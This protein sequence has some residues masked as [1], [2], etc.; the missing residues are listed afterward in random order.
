M[1]KPWI[2]VVV[3]VAVYL[4]AIIAFNIISKNA[5]K[6]LTTAMPEAELPVVEFCYN[7]QV[8][9]E[10]HGYV[11]KMDITGIRDTVTNIDESRQLQLHISTYGQKVDKISYEIRGLDNERFLADGE[12]TDFKIEGRNIDTVLT[13]QNLLEENEE[14]SL[15][16]I[17]SMGEK[18]VYYYTRIIQEKDCHVKECLDFA[19]TFHDYTFSDEAANFIPTYMD[20]ASGDATTLN[21]VDL[22]CTLRQITWNKF[23]GKKMGKPTISFL[24]INNNYVAIMLRYTMVNVNGENETEYYLVEEYYRLRYTKTRMYVMNF[25][26]TMNQLFN[27]ENNFITNG[28]D[29]QLGIRDK[30]VEYSSTEGGSVVAFVQQG[31]LWVYNS[32]AKEI[33]KVFS[34]R[35]VEGKDKRNN[36]NQYDINIARVDEAGSVDFIVYGYMNRGAHEGE[37]GISICHYDG[38]AHTVEEEAFIPYSKSFAILKAEMGRLMYQS[39]MGI[40]YFMMEGDVYNFNIGTLTLEKL[41]SNLKEGT[42]SASPAN[43]Y[44]AWIESH[45]EYS[46]EVIKLLDLGTG[47]EFTLKAGE[48]E[49]LRPLGFIGEDFIYGIANGSDITVNQSGKTIFPMKAIQIIDTSE[50]KMDVLK[51]YS[52]DG[53]YISGIE[54]DGYTIEVTLNTVDEKGNITQSTDLIRNKNAG[55]DETTAITTTRTDV[56]ETEVQISLKNSK[57]VNKTRMITSKIVILEEEKNIVL[58]EK[59][60]LN[61]YYVYEKGLVVLATDSLTEAI[62]A[63]NADSAVVVN[64]NQDYIWTKAK[65]TSV[66]AFRNVKV[67]S[68]DLGANSVVQSISALLEYKGIGMN[69]EALVNAG[70]TPQQI[71]ATTLQ[72]SLILDLT[73]CSVK[74]VLYYISNGYPVFASTGGNTAVL[75]IGYT[76]STVTYFNPLSQNQETVSMTEANTRFQ[77]VGN[78]F[79]TY[80]DK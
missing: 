23:E 7:E 3:L 61:R 10:L 29:I 38:I 67:N 35:E 16:L 70:S 48:G 18:E 49:Y 33:Q 5:N 73:G 24:E 66:K 1:K 31:E 28:K 13:V 36:W 77:A 59:D 71:L 78:I 74:E 43:K 11:S 80:L 46:S 45:K 26:R 68:A 41:I 52:V 34:F 79:F 25:E 62:K 51:T 8:V 76:G 50:G 30:N 60:K 22:S 4:A 55:K 75:L 56:K 39:D 32:D 20:V 69:V 14:Y 27:G 2:K 64:E 9:N 12:I 15:C 63:A 37:V 53:K 65:E 19:L 72:G 40:I 57:K 54:I 44:F 42:Y 17:L 21:Y 58:P 6:D 47:K